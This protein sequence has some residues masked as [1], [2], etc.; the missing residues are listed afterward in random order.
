MTNTSVRGRIRRG[1]RAVDVTNLKGE[2]LAGRFELGEL[3][4]EG[5]YGAVF[6]AV[7][8]SVSRPCAVKVLSPNL[9]ADDNTVERFRV[10]AQ[11]T[12]RLN[13]PNTVV[14]YDFGQDEDKSVLFLAMELLEGESLREVVRQEGPLELDDVVKIA[15]QV[16]GSLQEA[17]DAG[18]VHRDVKPHN[19]MLVERGGDDQFVKVIDFGIAKAIRE[20]IDLK[21]SLTRTGMMVGTPAYMAPEQV[22]DDEMDGRT[23]EY[24][25]ATSV[26]YMLTGT[27]P[28]QGGSSMEVASRHLQE[29]PRPVSEYRADG[30]IPD[31]FDDVLLRAL[32][33]S[34][35]E[36]FDTIEAF[37]TALENAAEG[38]GGTAE[39]MA[40]V[41]VEPDSSPAAPQEGGRGERVDPYAGTEAEPELDENLEDGAST[42]DELHRPSG[43]SESTRA[44]GPEVGAQSTR[45]ATPSARGG[46]EESSPRGGAD[47][48]EE[49]GGRSRG[50]EQGESEAGRGRGDSGSDP[51]VSSG[52]PEGAGETEGTLAVPKSEWASGEGESDGDE[53]GERQASVEAAPEPRDAPSET[54]SGSPEKPSSNWAAPAET[55][56]GR[57]ESTR[58]WLVWSALGSALLFAVVG[59]FALCQRA[60]EPGDEGGATAAHDSSDA[61]PVPEPEP[62]RGVD[63]SDA[64]DRP[65]GT[66]NEGGAPGA[67][68]GE[69]EGSVRGARSERFDGGGRE[70]GSVEETSSATDR[71]NQEEAP[72]GES[73]EEPAEESVEE[74]APDSKPGTIVVRLIPW[75]ELHVDGRRIESGGRVEV[76]LSPGR[77]VLVMKQNGETV[78][79]ETVRLGPGAR[80]SI[81]LVAP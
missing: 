11:T 52:E 69:S 23:D 44:E 1:G 16:A 42:T 28:F 73:D 22:R 21:K 12:S 81:E 3:I 53:S 4:G 5:G 30:K 37:A 15:G 38:G 40:P 33:K 18:T 49:D 79:R 24:A 80:R 48:K 64:G 41:H 2:T 67:D 74:S 70:V 19:V 46:A 61:A 51:G 56:S 17:H 63:V 68:V 34:K 66:E 78:A 50:G 31:S 35:H 57:E 71:E 20:G 13:H 75:G 55:P 47:S 59:P 39:S 43:E 29:R 62:G 77:H 10:E 9:V 72:G 65:D 54:G 60:P 27:A 25:L 7:Q 58:S 32:S 76:E 8:L 6:R 36:R 45:A 26:Y 14:L